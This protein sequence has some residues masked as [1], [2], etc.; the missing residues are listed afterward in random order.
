MKTQQNLKRA[1]VFLLLG[2]TLLF[3]LFLL[4]SISH[5]KQ[6]TREIARS[7]ARAH[8]NK[9]VAFRQWA[10]RHGGLYVPVSKET[11][12]NPY[13]D[14]IVTRDITKSDGTRLTL[15]NPAYAVRQ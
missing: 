12:P 5:L 4:F 14:H 11:S 1:T 10:T 15:M 13:L 3:G 6:T 9:D 8:F 2:W 7:E